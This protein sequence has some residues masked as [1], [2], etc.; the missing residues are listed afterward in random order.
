MKK[1]ALLVIG[2]GLVGMAPPS[3]KTGT[4]P[5]ETASGYPPCSRT[6]T[7]RCIQLYERGVATAANLAR[8]RELGARASAMGGPYEAPAATTAWGFSER[9]TS[10]SPPARQTSY[11]PCSRTVTDRCIQLYERGVRGERG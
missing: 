1:T 8:N 11:P 2:I 6:V 7:D 10:W 4:A 9:S 5:A 3:T